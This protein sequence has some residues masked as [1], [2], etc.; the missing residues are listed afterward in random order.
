MAGR[1]DLR[2]EEKE[3]LSLWK[4]NIP[5][6]ISVFLWRLACHSLP[7]GDILHHRNMA[8]HDC[9]AMCGAQDSWK[10]FLIDCNLA[11]CVWAL[12]VESVV[13]QVSSIQETHA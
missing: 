1:S 5:S 7:T 11:K 9:C 13:D 6:N 12:E 4:L 10:H 3:W 8:T 2:A